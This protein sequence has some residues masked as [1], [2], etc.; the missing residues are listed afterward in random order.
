MQFPPE[1]ERWRSLVSKYFPPELV[2][3][4][5]WTIQHESGGDP[6]AVGDKGVARGL[7]QIQDNRA[8]STRPDAAF[9][10]VPENNIKYAAEQLGAAAGNFGAWGEGTLHEGKPFGAF[11]N[12]SYD[13]SATP[14]ST[15][16]SR[17]PDSA[18]YTNYAAKHARWDALDKKT[19][20]YGEN[21][22]YRAGQGLF[23]QEPAGVDEY[24][25]PKMKEVLL[26][27]DAEYSEWDTLGGE[28]DDLE[29]E[30]EQTGGGSE[31]VDD[32][33]R[34]ATFAYDTDPRNIDAENAAARYG[35]ELDARGQA[36]SLATNNLR[37][38]NQVQQEAEGSFNDA[39]TGS[40][41]WGS[42]FRA[43]RTSLPTSEDIYSEAVKSVKSGLPDVP[44]KPY[45][46]GPPLPAGSGSLPPLETVRRTYGPG[47]HVGSDDPTKTV[48]AGQQTSPA[49]VT[50]AVAAAAKKPKPISGS[51][52]TNWKRPW[53]IGGLGR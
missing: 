12:N 4:A 18:W 20:P 35:R 43:P 31:G 10:D 45:Y 21:V 39:M 40:N 50:P 17:M 37:E 51:V 9:L 47:Q 6:A 41:R 32:A 2:D 38:Q 30:Y 26:L 49:D 53:D 25:R 42:T 52:V 5:L 7:F 44:D 46:S 48:L 28:L 8:F 36:V 15:G 3:K 16:G 27:S 13:G 19:R 33:I 14:M 11:G 22:F 29:A 23:G 1:T 24:G 34:R